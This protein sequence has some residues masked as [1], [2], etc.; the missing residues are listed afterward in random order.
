MKFTKGKQNNPRLP[1]TKAESIQLPWRWGLGL[2]NPF[3]FVAEQKEGKVREL[4][5]VIDLLIV[6]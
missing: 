1:N 6:H 4:I 2:C 3:C 5:F